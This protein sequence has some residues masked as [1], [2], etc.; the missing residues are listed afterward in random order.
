MAKMQPVTNEQGH[1]KRIDQGVEMIAGDDHGTTTIMIDLPKSRL[2]SQ[3]K[4]IEKM[5]TIT[6]DIEAIIETSQVPAGRRTSLGR[7]FS[8]NL[9]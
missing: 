6:A 4:M 9:R 2:V 3:A 5:T 1:P 7:G 8:R